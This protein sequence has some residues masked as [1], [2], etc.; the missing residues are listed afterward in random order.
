[1]G[2][3]NA[4]LFKNTLDVKA[5]HVPY[6]GGGP[7]ISGLLSNQVQ[8]LL[9]NLAPFLPY[10]IRQLRALA[11][12]RRSARPTCPTCR[13]SP[14]WPSTPN[15]TSWIG[16]RAPAGTPPDVI[17]TL[18]A[19]RA[20]AQEDELK[21]TLEKNGSLPPADQTPEQFTAMMSERLVMYKDLI[22]RAG[23]RPE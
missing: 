18:Q 5:V 9:D 15:T 8:F 20:V 22:E 4:E 7:L 1:M 3:L 19:V 2:Q 11:I 16:W 12:G 6:R 13:P 17:Q 14:N 23:I 10:A 21:L